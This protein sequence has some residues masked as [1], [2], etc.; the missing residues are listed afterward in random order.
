MEIHSHGI[1][2]SG[3]IQPEQPLE[4]P[5]NT[6]VRFVLI[7]ETETQECNATSAQEKPRPITGEELDELI[8]RHGVSAG[9]RVSA[10]TLRP[11]NDSDVEPAQL[12]SG[13]LIELPEAPRI[14]SEAFKERIR[15]YAFSAPSLPADFSREDIYID[16]D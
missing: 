13:V 6:K 4:L 15:K 5:D 11:L 2:K 3:V 10:G 8:R 12:P 16:H 7:P 1:Y 14:S 9:T